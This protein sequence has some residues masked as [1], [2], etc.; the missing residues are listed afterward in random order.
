MPVARHQSAS[1]RGAELRGSLLVAQPEAGERNV[2]RLT[3]GGAALFGAVRRRV[4]PTR[5]AV[6]GVVAVLAAVT[7]VGA[8]SAAPVA[9]GA[10]SRPSPVPASATAA[11]QV[12]A[13]WSGAGGL[14]ILDLVTKGG[15]V[16]ILL[17]VTL[18]VLSRLQ[19]AGPARGS[20]L[21]VLESR[22]LAPKASLHLVAVG[23][24]RLIV[25][26]TPGGMVALAE[27]DASEIENTQLDR[28]PAE[29]ESA[30]VGD[31]RP[32]GSRPS[33]SGQP[34]PAF[35]ATLNSV[36]API[37]GLTDRLAGFIGGGRGR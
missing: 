8:L 13:A 18:R 28:N 3:A 11:S 6:V 32:A 12:G 24:R 4:S 23:D 25:G 21:N 31:P 30:A 33:R 35:A 1:H 2:G 37:D 7:G 14:D 36:M 29:V 26:L 9:G 17:F 10:G 20:R 5:L 22:T 27:L 34:S 16:L 15:L 19:A